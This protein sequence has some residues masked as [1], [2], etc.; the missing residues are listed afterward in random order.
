MQL[1]EAVIKCLF[2]CLHFILYGRKFNSSYSEIR[3][4]RNPLIYQ[5]KMLLRVTDIITSSNNNI[6]FYT[7]A[8]EQSEGASSS[9]LFAA[10]LSA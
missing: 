3:N 9:V 4:Y 10:L 5:I 2:F 7:L 8:A 6:T 1:N